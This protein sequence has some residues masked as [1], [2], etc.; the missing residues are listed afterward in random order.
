M[1]AILTISILIFSQVANAL[2]S[3]HSKLNTIVQVDD[4]PILQM[5]AK[6]ESKWSLWFENPEGTRHSKFMKMHGK[7]MHMIVVSSDLEHFAHIHPSFNAETKVFDIHINASTQD[8]D[9]FALPETVS[10]AGT[11]F[12]FTEVMPMPMDDKMPMKMDR[13]SVSA[14]APLDAPIMLDS[15]PRKPLTLK[16]KSGG[17]T[18]YFDED[19]QQGELGDFYKL[20][21]SYENF[22]FCG[23]WLPKFYFEIYTMGPQGYE[24]SSGWKQWLEMGGHSILISQYGEDLQA[25]VFHH[26][27]AFLPISEP[28]KFIFP[29]DHHKPQLQAGVYKIWGQ[30]KNGDKILTLPVLFEYIFPSQIKPNFKGC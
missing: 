1:T 4:S 15:K 22:E 2:A 11:Y 21:F 24:L 12:A 8:P 14:V 30:F 27:H 6:E 26:L 10:R 16:E 28:G 3:P 5:K 17:Q 7:L 20:H 25:K 19:G 9:N 29:F 18:L 23:K 13:F